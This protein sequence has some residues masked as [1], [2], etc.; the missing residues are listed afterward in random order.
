MA[1]LSDVKMSLRIMIT[2][3]NTIHERVT[4]STT[5]GQTLYDGIGRAY[6]LR[7]IVRQ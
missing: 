2:R 6:L 1:W 3:F 7:D 5:D 4:D